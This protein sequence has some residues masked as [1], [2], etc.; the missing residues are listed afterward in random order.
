MAR[1]SLTSMLS[2]RR[3]LAA[4]LVLNLFDAVLTSLWV[5]SGVVGEGNPMM[6]QAIEMGFGPF[7]L[8]KVLLVGF[9]A[10]SLYSLRHHLAARVAVLPM[11]LLYCFVMGNHLGI[12]ARVLGIVERGILFGGQL[13]G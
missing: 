5:S 1:R 3:A 11:T 8:S 9:G 13:P 12:G 2:F 4:L 10:W 7:V 6:A